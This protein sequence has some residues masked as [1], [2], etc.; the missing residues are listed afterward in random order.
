MPCYILHLSWS[1]RL[2]LC[3]LR[4]ATP[5]LAFRSLGDRNAA[6]IVCLPPQD[7][8]DPSPWLDLH[9]FQDGDL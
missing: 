1:V 4:S 7:M 9:S 8:T 6:V 2:F 5:S 3:N